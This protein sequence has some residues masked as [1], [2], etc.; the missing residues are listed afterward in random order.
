MSR[1]FQSFVNSLFGS[2]DSAD[3]TVRFHVETDGAAHQSDEHQFIGSP[4]PAHQLV[5]RGGSE[6]FRAHIERWA[7]TASS[8]DDSTDRPGKRRRVQ[9]TTA[10][11][12]SEL[13]E[14]PRRLSERAGVEALPELLVPIASEDELQPSLAAIRFIYSGSVQQPGQEGTGSSG[15]GSCAGQGTGEGVGGLVRIRRQA[16]YLQVRDCAEACDAAMVA[17][18]SDRQ[19]GNG[20]GSSTA[21]PL[22]PV[23]ELYCCRHLLPSREEDPRVGPVLSACR[24]HLYTHWEAVLPA[25][26]S[27]GAA[28]A[29]MA[30]GGQAQGSSGQVDKAEVLA[31]LLGGGDAVRIFNGDELLVWWMAMPVAALEALLQ[32]DYLSTDDEA[33]V[34]VLVEYWIAAMGDDVTEADKARVRRQLRLVNCSTSYLFDV[35]PKLPWLGPNPA[36]QAAFLARCQLSSRSEWAQL[37]EKLGGYDM[38]SPW[39]GGPRPQSVPQEGVS[40]KWEVSRA[41]LLAAMQ[42]EGEEK[43]MVVHFQ[44][45][46]G[47]GSTQ[48]VLAFGYTWTCCLSC[49]P[50]GDRGGLHLKCK[51]PIVLLSQTGPLQGVAGVTASVSIGCGKPDPMRILDFRQAMLEYGTWW[52]EPKAV[53]LEVEDRAEGAGHAGGAG[54][55]PGAR[56]VDGKG[57]EAALLAPWAKYL[58]PGGKLM[59][60]LTFFRPKGSRA[61]VGAQQGAVVGQ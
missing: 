15:Q 39:Y 12:P 37:G 28:Q 1:P 40:Y 11:D 44:Q 8:G 35:L 29:G 10:N 31:W 55:T 7:P 48:T 21:S 57:D 61:A 53:P 45:A 25:A 24:E 18:F 33:T 3:C 54:G 47:A 52:G 42:K 20:S 56:E 2:R 49:A 14:E 19:G 51:V 16:E 9:Q 32:S 26:G 43:Y 30:Q 23:F 50:P 58:G 6:R 60:T 41:D 36:Q 27:S 22:S 13:E 59:G 34:V 17:C 4:L 38:S 46:E 5:L